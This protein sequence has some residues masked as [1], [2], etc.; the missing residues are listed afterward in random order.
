MRW[1]HPTR[2]LIS[3]ADFVPIA[4]EAGLS[5]QLTDEVLR[6]ATEEAARWHSARSDVAVALNLTEADIREL[7]CDVAQVLLA[8]PPARAHVLTA[9]FMR[10]GTISDPSIVM[11]WM[12][13][14]PTLSGL[15]GRRVLS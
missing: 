12:G 4:L 13:R 15:F 5:R 1:N 11:A 8:H 3:S 2:G 9:T 6:M 14:Q 10:G 7:D